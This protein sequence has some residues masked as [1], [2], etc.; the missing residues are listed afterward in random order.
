VRES[1]EYRFRVPS[2]AVFTLYSY[3]KALEYRFRVPTAASLTRNDLINFNLKSICRLAPIL[4]QLLVKREKTVLYKHVASWRPQ[5]WLSLHPMD[6]HLLLS[7]VLV[8][9]VHELCDVLC[10][11]LH[12]KFGL[13]PLPRG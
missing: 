12:N 10:V 13:I 4:A 1:I 9:G 2:A 5:Q 7:L 11:K 3:S 8:K 6:D